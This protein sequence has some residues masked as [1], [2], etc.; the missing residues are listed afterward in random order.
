M[1][2]PSSGVKERRLFNFFRRNRTVRETLSTEREIQENLDWAFNNKV[3]VRI[4][5]ESSSDRLEAAIVG[6]DHSS[7]DSYILLQAMG[8]KEAASVL[9]EKGPLILEYISSRGCRFVFYSIAL[10]EVH[11]ESGEFRAGYPS[12]IESYQNFSTVRLKNTGRDPIQVDVEKQRGVVVDIGSRGMRFTC[13]QVLD[14]GALLK[15]LQIDLP[16]YGTVQ[17]SAVV[18]HIQPSKDN[19]V[20]R[21]LCGAEFTEMKPRDR[22][23][24]NHY[25]ARMLK[26]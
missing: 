24:L 4:F 3:P 16:K 15:D 7:L 12:N 1:A 23:R 13:N 17:G 6:V 9:T 14:K 8:P 10:S 20:W 25:L 11:P 21:Y 2:I 22:K 18:R 26:E 19:P 5:T